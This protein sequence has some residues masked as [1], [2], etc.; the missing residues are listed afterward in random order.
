VPGPQA[1]TGQPKQNTGL[2]YY[3]NSGDCPP[4]LMAFGSFATF[5]AIRRAYAISNFFDTCASV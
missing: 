2:P 1:R 3:T 5:T 4:F